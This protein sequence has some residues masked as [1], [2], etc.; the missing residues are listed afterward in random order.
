M[1]SK[2]PQAILRQ[3]PFPVADRNT[4]SPK[5]GHCIGRILRQWHRRTGRGRSGCSV[6]T[7]RD[8]R[9]SRVVGPGGCTNLGPAPKA[10]C[11]Q[12][13]STA[14]DCSYILTS[15]ACAD[16]T[17]RH[18]VLC[19]NLRWSRAASSRTP[20]DGSD[21]WLQ[22]VP[23]MPKRAKELRAPEIKR[24]VRPGADDTIL[25]WVGGVTGL[26]LQIRATT[27]DCPN[28]GIADIQPAQ[29]PK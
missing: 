25:I 23:Q 27:K 17:V 9:A 28:L 11:V 4:A 18:V 14:V 12:S 1:I 26:C 13:K 2:R 29:K 24:F 19:C 6:G 21:V 10:V 8:S 22:K 3:R 20:W 5:L 16:I 15:G 7:A